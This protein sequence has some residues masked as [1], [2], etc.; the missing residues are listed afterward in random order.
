MKDNYR[1]LSYA[2]SEGMISSAEYDRRV[3]ALRGGGSNSSPKKKKSSWWIPK[4]WF[5]IGMARQMKKGKSKDSA[6]RAMKI[7]ANR[8]KRSRYQKKK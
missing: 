2:L 3:A 7:K 6:Y 1:S 5:N 8:K 4:K